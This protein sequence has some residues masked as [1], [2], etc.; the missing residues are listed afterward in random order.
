MTAYDFLDKWVTSP[1]LLAIVGAATLGFVIWASLA[2][3]EG[4]EVSFFGLWKLGAR[5]VKT[6]PSTEKE[7][8]DV[9]KRVEERLARL[10]IMQKQEQ[11]KLYE[12]EPEL[13]RNQYVALARFEIQGLVRELA[14]SWHGGWAGYATV[15]ELDPF[16]DTLDREGDID[17]D[18]VGAIQD[19]FWVTAPLLWAEVSDEELSRVQLMATDVLRR[20]KGARKGSVA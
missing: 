17:A 8:A 13:T 16:L 15:T 11:E 12:P 2:Y 9:E 7:L 5:P 18:L 4:R 14:V 20:L 19:F 10:E 3:R 1:W 6:A